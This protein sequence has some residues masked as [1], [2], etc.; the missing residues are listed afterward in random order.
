MYKLLIA[1]VFISTSVLSAQDNRDSLIHV[2]GTVLDS[3]GEPVKK[4]IIYVDSVKTFI[5]TNKRGFYT[6][7]VPS[8][9]RQMMAFSSKYGMVAGNLEGDELNFQF[10][11]DQLTVSENE[12][13]QMGFTVDTNRKVRVDPENYKDYNSIYD[14]I[15][16]MFTGVT[17]RGTDIRVRGYS[18][19]P[20]SSGD[21]NSFGGN[22]SEPLVVVDGNYVSS[23]ELG[24][25]L[26]EDVKSIELLKSGDTALYGARGAT[27]VLIITLKK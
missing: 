22:P 13:R 1:L 12:L 27:G 21:S 11:K 10:Q 7:D 16:A 23:T 14:L 3:K 5:K 9:T 25:W 18:S 4:A 15:K 17:V 6:I 20:P 26:P 2:K 24:Q 8:D 19:L